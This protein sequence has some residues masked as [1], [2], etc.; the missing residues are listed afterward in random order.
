MGNIWNKFIRILGSIGGNPE[1]YHKL[2]AAALT[3]QLQMKLASGLLESDSQP[4]SKWHYQE[5]IMKFKGTFLDYFY[6]FKKV[7]QNELSLCSHM[8]DDITKP[9]SYEECFLKFVELRLFI[10]F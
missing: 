8:E 4:D 5:Q 6:F 1:Q 3:A 9:L 10:S 7:K 2:T